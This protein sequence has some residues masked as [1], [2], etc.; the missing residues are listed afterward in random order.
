MPPIVGSHILL[1]CGWVPA[2][3]EGETV[4]D[5]LTRL[6]RTFVDTYI[7]KC[8]TT[9]ALRNSDNPETIRRAMQAKAKAD[10][11]HSNRSRL[12][13]YLIDKSAPFKSHR[14]EYHLNWKYAESLQPQNVCAALFEVYCNQ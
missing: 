9:A 2:C 8:K 10:F 7:H 11:M 13:Q 4:D 12:I 5:T 1:E 6:Y 3:V 14:I